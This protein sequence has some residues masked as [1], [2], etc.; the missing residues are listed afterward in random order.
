MQERKRQRAI[1]QDAGPGSDF[2]DDSEPAQGGEP[3]LVSHGTFAEELP[4]GGMTV[5]QVRSR[6]RDRLDIHPAAMALL[7]GHAVDDDT[8][9]EQGQMLAF[10]RPAGEKGRS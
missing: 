4:V 9:V 5:A 6:F 7:G 2:F 10:V 8:I 3:V 1:M